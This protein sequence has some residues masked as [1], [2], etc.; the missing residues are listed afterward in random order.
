VTTR[1][2]L[3]T[4]TKAY[5]ITASGYLVLDTVQL[6]VRACM[7]QYGVQMACCTVEIQV[8]VVSV[9]V[10]LVVGMRL[11]VVDPSSMLL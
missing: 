10:S 1:K 3:E 4:L 8:S 6:Q 5:T 9:V 7:H 2:R 11:P